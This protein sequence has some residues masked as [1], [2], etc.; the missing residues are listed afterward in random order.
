MLTFLAQRD[1]YPSLAEFQQRLGSLKQLSEAHVALSDDEDETGQIEKLET[2]ISAQA[3]APASAYA[4]QAAAIAS[5]ATS[6]ATPG[7]SDAS[8]SALIRNA[9]SEQN[10]SDVSVESA[11]SAYLR[12]RP[13]EETVWLQEKVI[14][15]LKWLEESNYG[16]GS[17]ASPVLL[18]QRRDDQKQFLSAATQYL[19]KQNVHLTKTEFASILNLVPV[20]TVEL[21]I[22]IE[23]REERLTQE[24]TDELV[25]LVKVH[26]RQADEEAE[27]AVETQADDDNEAPLSSLIGQQ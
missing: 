2:A 23:E 25:R 27:A 15:Y 7:L 3:Q 4:Q 8:K 9:P 17:A 18:T 21:S 10:S 12:L 24:Q 1:S 14:A 20:S 16:S 22:I 6:D 5:A 13:L 11:Q 19:D 26:L